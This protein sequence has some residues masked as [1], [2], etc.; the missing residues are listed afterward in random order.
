MRSHIS[1]SQRER[2]TLGTYECYAQEWSAWHR[3]P[4]YWASRFEQF[5]ELLPSGN[6]ID[7]GCGNALYAGFF[8]AAG[9]A[10]VGIDIAAAM[11]REAKRQFRH[12]LLA[13]MSMYSLGFRRD[14]FDGFIAAASFLHITPKRRLAYVLQEVKRVVRPGGIGF[15]V[16]REG[17]GEKPITD[18]GLGM[19]FFALYQREEFAELLGRRGFEVIR[20]WKDFRSFN[21]PDSMT[22]WLCYFVRVK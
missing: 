20:D 10:Y 22:V 21:P 9:Y 17:S 11:L 14:T 19:R 6:V 3:D 1:L 8:L 15:I 18:S 13:R 12:L 4:Q 2:I 5:Q 7:L 16:V